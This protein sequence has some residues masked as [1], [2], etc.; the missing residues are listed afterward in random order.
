MVVFAAALLFF[1]PEQLPQVARKVGRITRDVQNTSQAFLREMERAAD[2]TD[3]TRPTP[4]TPWVEESVTPAQ[5]APPSDHAA[6][7][8]PATEPEMLEYSIAEAAVQSELSEAVPVPFV[9]PENWYGSHGPDERW[10]EL[11]PALRPLV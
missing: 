5:L 11:R 4:P 9:P 10:P 3:L 1:G 7:A 8:W 2:L 6:E